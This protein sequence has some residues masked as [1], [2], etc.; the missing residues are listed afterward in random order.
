MSFLAKIGQLGV[1]VLWAAHAGWVLPRVSAAEPAR[2]LTIDFGQEQGRVEP[3]IGFLG[4]LRDGTPDA[5]IQPLHPALWRI[6]H[7][8][9]G[10]I[11][12]GL[13]GAIA[14]GEGLGAT[15][16]LVMS[17]LIGDKPK[18]FADYRFYG[19]TKGQT[20]VSC[21]GSDATLAALASKTAGRYEVLL[22]S[23]AL[24]ATQVTLKL[25]G[26]PSD[27]KLQV[28]V[29]PATNLDVPLTADHIPLATDYIA[30]P[31]QSGVRAIL[32]RVEANQAYRLQ[33]ARK[34]TK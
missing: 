9:R 17:D 12:A 30:E 7:Q 21:A 26:L 32:V 20:R 18:D 31:T 19:E 24:A 29:L 22:G 10:R 27:A 11:A 14:R 25:K 8:F 2:T 4:G 6:G 23:V 15:Y 1:A 13:P 5:L 34:E 33:F 3:R 16:K 28:R